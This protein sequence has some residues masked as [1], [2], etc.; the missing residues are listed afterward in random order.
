MLLHFFFAYAVF[1]LRLFRCCVFL[2]D[3]IDNACDRGQGGFEAAQQFGEQHLSGRDICNLLHAFCV[4]NNA[5][6][7]TC[8]EFQLFYILCYL[9]QDACA[10]CCIFIRESECAG[11]CQKLIQAF[12]FC[13]QDSRMLHC[14]FVYII[15]NA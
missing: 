15:I 13:A 11:A 2:C 7:H 1:F 9:V 6:N 3:L 5:F 4:I 8:F 14:I 10:C 12:T